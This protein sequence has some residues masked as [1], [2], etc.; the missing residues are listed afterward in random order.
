MALD[1]LMN[2]EVVDKATKYFNET[3]G[4]TTHEQVEA[5]L[6]RY[7]NTKEGNLSLAKFL[8]N[9]NLWS[10]AE[11][12]RAITKRLADLEI[13]DQQSLECWVKKADFKREVKG[14][15]RAGGHSIGPVLFDWLQ[16]RCGVETVKADRHVKNFV[17]DAV[18]RRVTAAEAKRGVMAVAKDSGRRASLLDSAIWHSQHDP[19]NKQKQVSKQVSV[20]TTDTFGACR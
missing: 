19:A 8:W 11:F 2:T 6:A 9:Y 3:H 16:L 12:L 1:F 5:L 18:G 13:R 20:L 4:A 7:P 17:S 10:R 15:F 14:Q